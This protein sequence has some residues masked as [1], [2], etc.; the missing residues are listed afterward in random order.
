MQVNL[1]FASSFVGLYW[2]DDVMV[3]SSVDLSTIFCKFMTTTEKEILFQGHT[4]KFAGFFPTRCC[5]LRICYQDTNMQATQQI[6]QGTV[7]VFL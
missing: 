1:A 6:T 3:K 5:L 4:G 7:T 2:R